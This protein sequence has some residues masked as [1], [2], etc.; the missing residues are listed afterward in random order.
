M[1]CATQYGLYSTKSTGLKYKGH[2]HAAHDATMQWRNNSLL[3][4]ENGMEFISTVSNLAE[5]GLPH[6][7]LHPQET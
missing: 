4:C 6:G 3:M 5:K 7:K 2:I 1:H